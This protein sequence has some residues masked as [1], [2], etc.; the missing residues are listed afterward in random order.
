M[1][2][3]T[4]NAIVH[5]GVLDLGTQFTGKPFSQAELLEEVRHVLDRTEPES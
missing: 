4:D 2:G 5:H 1:S 3:Y